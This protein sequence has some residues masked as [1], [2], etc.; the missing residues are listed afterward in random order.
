MNK[1][2]GFL[3][4]SIIFFICS[5]LIFA[6]IAYGAVD[7]WALGIIAILTFLICL[8][9]L[10]K[11]WKTKEFT[12]NDNPIQLPIIGLILIGL[13]QLLPL[14]SVDLSKLIS[15]QPINSLSLDPYATR[16]AVVL[17]TI[18]LI[19][20]A[21]TLTFVT[22][23]KILKKIAVLLIS[24]G[25]FFAF[26]GILQQLTDKETI[27][28][29]RIVKDAI[30]FG[31]F[32]N[33]HHFA[34]FMVMLNGLALGLVYNW[35]TT[36][37]RKSLLWIVIALMSI[38]LAMTGSRGAWLSFLGSIVFLLA[39]SSAKG[40][41]NNQENPNS[42]K[43]IIGILFLI[44]T[45]FA[46]VIF[47]GEDKF[48]IRG[49]GLT[50]QEDI[51]GGR[52]H[53]WSVAWQVFKDYPILGTGLDSFATVFPH[54]DKWNGRFRVER[55][56]NDYLQMLADAGLV[57]FFCVLIFIY[58]LFNYGIKSIKELKVNNKP[59]NSFL[60][61]L[62]IGALTGCFGILIHSFFDFPLRTNSNAFYFLMLSA[63]SIFSA[64]SSSNEISG[65]H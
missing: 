27:F 10:F 6:P 58:L 3:E 37:D 13:I 5:I 31:T 23:E 26:I 40:Q 47:L 54:Y 16:F 24:F 57:G 17:L 15:V 34:A 20:F 25:A 64:R 42:R 11:T 9:W 62:K 30:P 50:P 41:I 36:K 14:R 51:S 53:F 22:T 52:F 39:I 33:R 43:I 19:F 2:F 61:G 56:H 48:L 4:S 8:L 55:A 60:L 35:K 63:I 46:T 1:S 44:F 21:A 28:G 7:S 59:E 45:V 49:I 38:A 12:F 29:F 18:Y 32:V 65:G